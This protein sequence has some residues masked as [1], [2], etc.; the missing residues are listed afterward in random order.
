MLG[1]EGW[2]LAGKL[3]FARIKQAVAPL[4]SLSTECV[5]GLAILSLFVPFH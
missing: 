2:R 3:L 5:S 1:G 4:G